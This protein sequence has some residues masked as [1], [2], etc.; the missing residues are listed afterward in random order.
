[1]SIESNLFTAYRGGRLTAKNNQTSVWSH[2]RATKRKIHSLA[3]YSIILCL[4]IFH[5]ALTIIR[6]HR[7]K[8]G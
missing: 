3:V 8:S 2:M 7:P 1:M 6:Y 4:L 5:N